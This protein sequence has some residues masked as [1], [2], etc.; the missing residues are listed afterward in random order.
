[1]STS[2]SIGIV[3]GWGEYPLAVAR[4][5][6][7]KGHTVVVAAVYDHA[8]KEIEALSHHVK[9]I[10]VCKLGGMQKFFQ[11]HGVKHVCLSGKLFKDRILF[12]GWG[13]MEHFPDWECI[14]TMLPMFY[15]RHVNTNDDSLLGAVVASFGRHGIKTI[16]GTDFATQL[17][18]EA[19]GLTR[20]KPS[21]SELGD[22]EFGWSIAKQMGG[23]DVGQSVT[24]RD[25]TIL[26]VEAIEGTDACI[27][28]TGQICTRGGFTLVKVAKPQ[29]D[30]RFDVPTIGP[31]TIEKM[32][33][34]GGKVIA[35]EAG[36][37]ILINREKTLQMADE[38]GI[39][40]LSRV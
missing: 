25:R 15:F 21:K 36:K 1:M 7:E 18:A 40:I 27:V 19:G 22:I 33:L 31:Q 8:P 5:L 3:A 9:W 17:L 29:Q 30:M 13:W 20:R 10:G 35:I 26:A 37:T 28:R 12:H 38:L 2:E 16:P 14:K 11:Q 32:K 24:V 34:A 4:A 39:A 6:R 23:L